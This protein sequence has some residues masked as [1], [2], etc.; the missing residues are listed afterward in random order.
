MSLVDLF[1]IFSSFNYFFFSKLIIF[2]LKPKIKIECLPKIYSVF[3]NFT[4]TDDKINVYDSDI[5]F[6]M[7]DSRPY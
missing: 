3:I 5:T 6:D 7:L 1:S 2:L 4:E